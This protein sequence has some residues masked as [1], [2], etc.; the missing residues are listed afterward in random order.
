[1][2]GGPDPNCK[3]CDR[4]DRRAIDPQREIADRSGMFAGGTEL[5]IRDVRASIAIQNARYEHFST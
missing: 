3:G 2:K 4:E 5:P 1:V